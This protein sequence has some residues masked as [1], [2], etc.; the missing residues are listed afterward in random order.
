MAVQSLLGSLFQPLSASAPQSRIC[1]SPGSAHTNSRSDLHRR[2]RETKPLSS[3]LKKT[4]NKKF[5]EELAMFTFFKINTSVYT[6]RLAKII[7]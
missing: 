3:H 7:E 1:L 6:L 5:W 2:R 4:Q